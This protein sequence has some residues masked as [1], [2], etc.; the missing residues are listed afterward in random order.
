MPSHMNQDEPRPLDM[1]VPGTDLAP[2]PDAP[3]AGSTFSA[4]IPDDPTPERPRR[5][6]LWVIPIVIVVLLAAAGYVGGALYFQS[7][8]LPGT[9]LDGQDVSLR[10]AEEVAAEKTASLDGFSTHVTGYGLDLTVSAPEIGLCYDGA[11]YVEEALSQTNPWAWPIE[12]L[13]TRSL[14]V[15]A[16]PAFDEGRLGELVTP[17]VE[18]IAR[19]SAESVGTGISYDAASASFVLDERATASLLDAAAVTSLVGQAVSDLSPAVE[20][21]EGC[22]ADAGSLQA[23]V[24]A[25]NGY[26]GAAGTTLLISGQLVLD[27]SP[28]LLAGW[29]TIGDDLSVSLDEDAIGQ[30]VSENVGALDTAGTTRTYT[31]PDGKQVS[32]SGGTWGI[33]TN[34]AE[35]TRSLVAAIQGGAPQQI[36]IT[37]R[38]STGHA[39]E[40]GG[41]DWGNRYIDI[42]ITEQYV[43][44]YGDD[45]SLIFESACV[46]GDP[47]MDYDT[48]TGIN[49]INSNKALDQVLRGLDYDEDGEPDYETPVNYWIPFVGNMVALHDADWRSSFGGSVYKGNGSHGCVNL[50]LS[51][52]AELYDLTQVGDVVVVHY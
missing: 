8:F 15:D 25:A 35:T 45:G 12:A 18:E 29:V 44:M 22:L 13:S 47:T 52:A 38:Q 27:V 9:T 39:P 3:D 37:L 33:V 6:A 17:A 51:K 32:V 34:E 40:P 4:P 5:R 7:R 19:S 1:S 43:R 26:L 42:D 50:P 20:V 21:D 24:D 16:E 10:S 49:P 11:A 28:D 2:G 36:E 23:A 46:T 14:S 30:W 41:K 48:P 31:R